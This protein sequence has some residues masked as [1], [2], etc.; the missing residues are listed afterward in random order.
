VRTVELDEQSQPQLQRF[1][2][3]NPEYFIAVE[4]EPAGPN[5]AHETIQAKPPPGWSFTK[6]WL[7]GYL[8]AGGSMIAVAEVVTD[9]LAPGVWHVGL[10]ILA[11]ERHGSGEARIMMGGLE[12]WAISNGAKWLRLSVVK[13]NARAE[14]FWELLG[15]QDART[16]ESVEM[17][18]R[19]NSMRIMFKP[20]TGG[21]RAQYLSLVDRDRPEAA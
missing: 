16:R 17:G 1:F 18:K 15:F 19:R 14:R 21:T 8:N 7:I 13:G 11:T 3:D 6:Q 4:G 5:A 12:S 20:L 9:L 2:E 10:F